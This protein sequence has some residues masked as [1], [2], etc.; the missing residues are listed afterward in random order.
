MLL[1][2]SL[3]V[4]G[5]MS[6]GLKKATMKELES[7]QRTDGGWSLPSLGDWVGNDER[8][9]DRTAP[10][11]GYATG[12]V[13]YVMRQAGVPADNPP[14]QRGIAWL[15]QNQRTSGMW[16]T[17]SLNTDRTH[18]ITHAGTAYAVM[19]LKACE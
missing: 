5:L 1:W 15:K 11:D 17:R 13:I 16:F 2:A 6:D 8:P 10:S 18:F 4:N 19:A 3:K 7:L 9:N 12:L 14:I